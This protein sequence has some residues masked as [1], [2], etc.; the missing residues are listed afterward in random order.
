PRVFVLDTRDSTIWV[1]GSIS[2]ATE[3]LELRVVTT[4]KDFSPLALRTPVLVR[5]TF[6]NPRV[7]V[8][9]GKLGT[10]L[11]AA[12]LLALVNP[13]AALIPLM[14]VGDSADAQRGADA[15]RALSQRIKAKPLLPAPGPGR[16]KPR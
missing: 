15:C 9:K 5:G 13:L 7:S 14:D 10:R 4:P 6:A 1:D 2:L 16:R 12:A 8:D 3:A 11:G